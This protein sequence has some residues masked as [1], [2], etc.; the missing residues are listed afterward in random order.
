MSRRTPAPV[1]IVPPHSPAPSWGP[2]PQT[3]A[4]PRNGRG[5]A[6]LADGVDHAATVGGKAGGGRGHP[7]V[8]EGVAGVGDLR[9]AAVVF[10][11]GRG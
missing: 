3:P 8:S 6:E 9:V 5:L 4:V 10:R 11:A 2:G 1:L 7:V